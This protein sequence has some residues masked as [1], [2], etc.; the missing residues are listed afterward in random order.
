MHFSLCLVE[1]LHFAISSVLWFIMF[2]SL[3]RRIVSFSVRQSWHIR[4]PVIYLLDFFSMDQLTI[5]SF[6]L[7]FSLCTNVERAVAFF[8]FSDL[9]FDWWPLYRVLKGPSVEP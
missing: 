4:D 1:C 9:K 6:P 8:V 2:L 5:T 3:L 7:S